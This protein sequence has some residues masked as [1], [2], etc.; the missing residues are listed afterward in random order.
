[1]ASGA[2]PDMFQFVWDVGAGK[3]AGN[4]PWTCGAD[5]VAKREVIWKDRERSV[6]SRVR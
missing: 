3:E 5:G 1:M 6:L 2:A 4:A